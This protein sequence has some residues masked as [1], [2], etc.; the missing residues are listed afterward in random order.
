[1]LLARSKLNRIEKISKALADG[2][3][4][5]EEFTLVSNE[6]ENYR[7]LKKKSIRKKNSRRGRIEKHKLT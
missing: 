3:I 7:K 2:E 5:Y 4:I 6:A 1:M